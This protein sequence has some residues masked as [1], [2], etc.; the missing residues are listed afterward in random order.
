MRKHILTMLALASLMAGVAGCQR[1]EPD[2]AW[3]RA[4]M[5]TLP[6]GV[7]ARDLPAPDSPGARRPVSS[8]TG[9]SR[10]APE[11]FDGKATPG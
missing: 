9:I 11:G 7:S 4:D 2:G 5:M 10:E 8:L 1:G 3:V 6:E